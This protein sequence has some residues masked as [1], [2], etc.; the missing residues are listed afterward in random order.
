[1]LRLLA[2]R[3]LSSLRLPSK[4]EATISFIDLA[5]FPALTEAHGD[6]DAANIATRFTQITTTALAPADRLIKSIGDAVLVTSESPKAMLALVDRVLTLAADEPDFPSLRA[7][8]HHGPIVKR[9]GDVFGAAVN[10]AAR[11]ASEAYSGEVLS[12][13]SVAAVA[14]DEGIAPFDLGVVPLKNVC[15]PIRLFSL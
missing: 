15:E 6:E 8:I 3:P 2:V 9:G 10:L 1:M 12:T 11:V 4:P 7:G 13:D 5:G 14:R